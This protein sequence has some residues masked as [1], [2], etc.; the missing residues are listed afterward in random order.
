MPCSTV[1]PELGRPW[2]P[3]ATFP[4]P[5]CRSSPRDVLRLRLMGSCTLEFRSLFYHPTCSC[6]IVYSDLPFVKYLP[7]IEAPTDYGP[8]SP[9]GALAASYRGIRYFQFHPRD[10]SACWRKRYF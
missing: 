8:T 3:H 7:S 6:S 4:S 5:L 1:D 9:T 2:Q 10:L